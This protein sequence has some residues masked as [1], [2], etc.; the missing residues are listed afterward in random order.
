MIVASFDVGI[1]NLAV[2]VV[3]LDEAGLHVVYWDVLRLSEASCKRPDMD[4]IA[5]AMF[6][7][8]D[9]LVDACPGMTTILI[10]NQPVLRN[11]IMKSVQMLL[12]SYFMMERHR[13]AA[14]W[15]V[16]FVAASQKLKGHDFELPA[17]PK[18]GYAKNKWAAVEL[19]KRYCAP[20]A[21]LTARLDKPGK[22]DDLSDSLLQAISW[23]RK[24]MP[25]QS[26]ALCDSM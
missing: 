18:T 24:A 7:C 25:S 14:D 23:I 6:E 12:Y 20:V 2:A 4:A 13:G 21:T 5:P 9:A 26:L 17:T 3:S 11:P 15:S 1:K 8:L 19:A 22:R 16:H 10:E